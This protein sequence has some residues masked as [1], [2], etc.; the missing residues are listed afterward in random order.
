MAILVL[1]SKMRRFMLEGGQLMMVCTNAGP[2]PAPPDEME[3]WC[4]VCNEDAHVWCVGCDGDPYCNRCWREGHAGPD[5][6]FAGH[7]KIPISQARPAG[8][9]AGEDNLKPSTRG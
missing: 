4:I 5:A 6:S 2:A 1:M 3:R 8:S 9:T 7:R